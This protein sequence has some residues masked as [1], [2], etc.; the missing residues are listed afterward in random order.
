[1]KTITPL[2]ALFFLLILVG[3]KQGSE[4][5]E[6]YQDEVCAELIEFTHES[7]ETWENEDVETYMSYLDKDIINMYSYN[8]SMNLEENREGFK[9]LFE[10]YSIEDVNFEV[11][12]CFVD[13][14]DDDQIALDSF[15][16]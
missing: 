8:L 6:S 3:C 13:H 15:S 4:I 16:R 5:S 9:D 10:T 7:L 11:V 2:I 1:M 12:E 14:N